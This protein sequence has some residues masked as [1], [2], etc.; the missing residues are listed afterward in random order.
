[1]LG[2]RR[3]VPRLEPIVGR[4]LLLEFEGRPYRVYVEEAGAGGLEEVGYL[5]TEHDVVGTAAGVDL[6]QIQNAAIDQDGDRLPVREGGVL[7]TGNSATSGPMPSSSVFRERQ[8]QLGV[9]WRDAATFL[10]WP[11]ACRGSVG[12]KSGEQ[13]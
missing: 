9:W 12:L 11:C 1:M 5:Q 3:A 4:Y 2:E 6:L 13:H 8:K 10:P 7:P